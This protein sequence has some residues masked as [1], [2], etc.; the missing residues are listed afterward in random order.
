MEMDFYREI[1]P[2]NDL[3]FHPRKKAW[4][5]TRRSRLPIKLPGDEFADITIA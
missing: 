3:K 1:K 5:R 4:R 2:F